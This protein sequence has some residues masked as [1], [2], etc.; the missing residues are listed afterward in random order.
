MITV[1]HSSHTG[2]AHVLH[3]I[4]I[5]TVQVISDKILGHRNNGMC[6]TGGP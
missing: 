3:V 2:Q 5:N 4:S 6:I 1:K